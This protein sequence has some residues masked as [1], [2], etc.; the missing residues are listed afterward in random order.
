MESTPEIK[1]LMVRLSELKSKLPDNWGRIIAERTSYKP[2]TV[3]AC[4][5]CT[6][7]S[8]KP[9]YTIINAA[10]QLYKESCKEEEQ[11][12]NELSQILKK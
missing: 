10:I 1:D 9:N 4:L 8:R 7:T 2:K 12:I 11:T 5:S 3:Y 6:N